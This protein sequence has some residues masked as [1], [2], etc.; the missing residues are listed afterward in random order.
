MKLTSIPVSCLRR[1]PNNARDKREYTKSEIAHPVASI[2]DHG[3][4][5]PLIVTPNGDGHLI[6]AGHR[7]HVALLEIGS[8]KAPCVVLEGD[9]RESL[10]V[11]LTENASHKAVD[12]L[13]EATAVAKLVE[14]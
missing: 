11:L 10:A 12:P 13:K 14:G 1:H 7:R 9:E 3:L 6:L 2:G 5:Q 4:L 8:D